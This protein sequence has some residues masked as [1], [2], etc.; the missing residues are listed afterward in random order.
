MRTAELLGDVFVCDDPRLC[1]IEGG[2]RAGDHFPSHA[3]TMGLRPWQDEDSCRR[4]GST[5][6]GGQAAAWLAAA[7]AQYMDGR[8][9]GVP[10]TSARTW[11][12]WPAYN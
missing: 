12:I 10:C 3:E 1:E 11:F 8:I 5:V 9:R 6:I 4:A 7:G 2:F